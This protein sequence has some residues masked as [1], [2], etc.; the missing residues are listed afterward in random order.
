MTRWGVLL[1]TFDPLRRAG[2]PEVVVA[3]RRAE[4]LGFDGVWVGDHLACPAPC[5]EATICLAAAAAVTDRLTLG[6]SV[7]LLGLRPPAWAAKQL[8]SLQLL[9]GGRLALGVGVGGEFP[10]E[11]AAVGRSVRTRGAALDAALRAL[12]RLLAGEGVGEIPPLRPPAAMPRLLVGGRSDAALR[13]AARLADAWMPMWLSPATLARRAEEL[14]AGA[15]EAGRACPELALLVG[16]RVEEDRS[17]ARGQAEAH[18]RGL[19]G[20]GLERVERWTPVGDLAEVGEQL[21][22]YVEAG[23]AEIVLMPLGSDPLEQIERLSELPR[24]I[25]SRAR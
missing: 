12:P 18:L 11:F 5:L 13:R 19:Y 7:M 8:A 2:A 24:A 22:G 4:E 9:S 17:R 20:L 16:V 25:P 23:A 1:P 14:A 3:A 21:A 6:L 15:A 10:Q